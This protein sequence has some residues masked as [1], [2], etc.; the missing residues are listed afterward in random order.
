MPELLKAANSPTPETEACRIV[1]LVNERGEVDVAAPMEHKQLCYDILKDAQVVLDQTHSRDF[2]SG[3]FGPTS[4]IVIV[5]NMA[6]R[7]DVGAPLPNRDYCE[8]MLERARKVIERFDDAEAPLLK[9]FPN[10]ILGD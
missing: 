1:L 6:G 4:R 8:K 10:A 5:M 9:P 3:W 7:V 2:R